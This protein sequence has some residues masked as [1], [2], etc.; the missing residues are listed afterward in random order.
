MLKL[1]TN[2]FKDSCKAGRC[3][4]SSRRSS[5]SNRRHNK[6][7]GYRFEQLKR[8]RNV[9]QMPVLQDYLLV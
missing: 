8:V 6:Q 3:E 7:K 2:V 4:M 1:P 9:P 5:T